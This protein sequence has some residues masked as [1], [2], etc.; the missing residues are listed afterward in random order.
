MYLKITGNLLDFQQ[1]RHPS[2]LFAIQIRRRAISGK[3]SMSLSTSTLEFSLDAMEGNRFTPTFTTMS[4]PPPPDPCDTSERH[5]IKR[6]LKELRIGL[7]DTDLH[8]DYVFCLVFRLTA[9]LACFEV[10][11][12]RPS[13][14]A[15]HATKNFELPS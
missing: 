10:E 15:G 3:G 1:M 7:S 13:N 14:G 12:Q 2:N 4:Q 5:S 8:P 9:L 6:R 11:L